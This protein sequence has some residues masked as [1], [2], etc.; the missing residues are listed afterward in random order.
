[1]QVGITGL[2]IRR[3]LHEPVDHERRE[4]GRVFFD[5]LIDRFGEPLGRRVIGQ[6]TRQ[7]RVGPNTFG[8]R[9]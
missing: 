3:A 6:E 4:T 2:Q 7:M 5:D 1:M 8:T 9:P